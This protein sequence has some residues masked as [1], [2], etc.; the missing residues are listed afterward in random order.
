MNDD[1]KLLYLDALRTGLLPAQ[2]AEFAGVRLA[3][4]EEWQAANDEFRM[5]CA[6]TEAMLESECIDAIINVGK[7]KTEWR[8]A[9]WYLER[10]FPSRWSGKDMK[11]EKEDDTD[12]QIILNRL[13]GI[14]AG[15]STGR[16]DKETE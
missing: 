12:I 14:A 4:I 1:G 2:A 11:E 3:L 8:A 16:T 9:A 6:A 15:A 5:K 13:A 10:R 7:G